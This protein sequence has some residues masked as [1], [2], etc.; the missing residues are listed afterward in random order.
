MPGYSG[1]P[2]PPVPT[3]TR[4]PKMPSSQRTSWSPCASATPFSS[5][6]GAAT[7]SCTRPW[8]KP[9]FPTCCGPCPVSSPAAC[10]L[11]LLPLVGWGQ[12]SREDRQISPVIHPEGG[13]PRGS[14][15][16]PPAH[17]VCWSLRVVWTGFQPISL[18]HS[19]SDTDILLLK[20]WILH[21][22]PDFSSLN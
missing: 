16:S 18:L 20:G 14:Q 22:S 19:A 4:T 11:P 2:G 10:R 1:S 17:P 8:W 9:S 6:C 12:S 3:A 13:G 15:G 5:G 7:T 21:V